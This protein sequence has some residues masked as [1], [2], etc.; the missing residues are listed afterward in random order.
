MVFYVVSLAVL[1]LTVWWVFVTWDSGFFETSFGAFF[2]SLG[3]IVV[4]CFAWFVLA[5]G[6]TGG[7]GSLVTSYEARGTTEANLAAVA[8]GAS[9]EGQFRGGIFASYG[10]I[11]GVRVISY[12]TRGDDDG[13]RARQ[14]N[15][16]D[17]VIFEGA[18]KPTVETHRWV[19]ENGWIFPWTLGTTYTY[20]FR[21]PEG[22]VVESYEVTP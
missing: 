3:E 5:I 16:D 7:I 19:K 15:A 6:A 14:V 2:A 17:A 9:I 12:L 22:S 13:I 10:Y 20:T 18:T 8:T 21:V 11:E 1:A 4:G